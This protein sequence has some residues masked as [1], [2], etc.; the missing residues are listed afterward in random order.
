[1][2]FLVSAGEAS[3]DL[4][5]AGVTRH[6][7]AALPEAHFYG[8]AGPRLQAAGVEPVLDAREIAVVGLAEV[9]HH[10]PRIYLRYR[11]LIRH[12][13]KHPPVAALLTDSPDFHLRLARHLHRL[14]VPVFYL[15]APQVW[16]WREGRVAT[17]RR[18]VDKLFCLF[19]FEEPWFRERGVD[20]SYIGHPLASM[21]R[22]Q[23]SRAEFLARH[24]IRGD[25]PLV[26]LLPGSR[27]G[28]ARRHLPVLLEAAALLEGDVGP[29][30]L[31]ATPKGFESHS[32]LQSFRE[33]LAARSIKVVENEAWDAIAHAD[34][35]LAASG[36]VTIE[37]AVLG[38][39]MVTFYK[40]NPLSWHAG[41]RL[42]KVPYLSMVNLVAGRKIVPELIQQ[43]MTAAN[44]AAA[45]SELLTNPDAAAGMRR[46]LAEV[47]G[48]L[49]SQGD[50]LRRAAEMI[51]AS[52]P[53][54][55]ETIAGPDR[56]E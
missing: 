5:A 42:V 32:V 41:R 25:R 6:L 28:E 9:V 36:T 23:Y 51:L 19:P 45:A 50:P 33:P 53:L 48:A 27:A 15:V 26:T 55:R 52:A 3:S 49:S 20:A 18:L 13:E 56:R 24:G 4:Y 47:R 12:I 7:A 29:R 17:I 39:P 38:T 21:V 22:P 54:R 11:A 31:L 30:F 14:G 43:E 1:M 8:C 2:Q 37:A 40:V 35:A 16:A 10:L 46:E 34:V 44:I